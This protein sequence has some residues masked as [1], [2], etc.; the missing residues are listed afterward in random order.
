MNSWDGQRIA[1]AA[2]GAGQRGVDFGPLTKYGPSANA[3]S[4]K[5]RSGSAFALIQRPDCHCSG[6]F[7]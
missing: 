5:G 3:A 6:C 2:G 1:S 4:F 7:V